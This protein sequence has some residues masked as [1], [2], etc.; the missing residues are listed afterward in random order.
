MFGPRGPGGDMIL[1]IGCGR[2]GASLA[3]RF[4]K[5]GESV[6]VLDHESRNFDALP[7]DFP[8]RTIEG[9]EIDDDILQ[10]AGIAEARAVIACSKDENTNMM[11]ADVAKR[12]FGVPRVIVRIDEPALAALY[13][14]EGYEVVTPIEDAAEGVQRSLQSAAEA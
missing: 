3:L 1:I 6:T 5:T 12:V 2:L 9:M 4:A 8:G 14:S 11:A 7:R 10:K 13:R